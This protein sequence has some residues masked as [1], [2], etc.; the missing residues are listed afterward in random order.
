MF[1]PSLHLIWSPQLKQFQ[2]DLPKD[3]SHFSVLIQCLIGEE[4]S[5][6]AD[7]FSFAV[8]TPN[9]MLSLASTNEAISGHGYLFLKTWDPELIRRTVEQWVSKAVAPDWQRS[10]ALLCRYM[11]WEYEEHPAMD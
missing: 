7:M 11:R 1:K 10:A 8:V 6:A 2:T 4:N 3:P 9:H 5:T